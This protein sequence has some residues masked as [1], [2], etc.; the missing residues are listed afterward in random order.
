MHK[1]TLPAHSPDR[2]T[3]LTKAVVRAVG[4][5]QLTQEELAG[6][7]HTSPASISRVVNGNR[8]IAPDGKE[9]ELALLLLRIFRS[10]DTVVGGDEQ[11]A[12]AWLRA[13]NR[14]LGAVPLDLMATI[15]GL[16]NVA[17]YLDAMR[18]KL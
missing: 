2:A 16:V 9:G 18:G 14:H 6:I 4:L 10:L 11:K 12:R 7:L 1:A 13:H 15:T 5:L 17:D 8:A 3:V